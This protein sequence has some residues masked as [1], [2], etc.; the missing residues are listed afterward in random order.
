MNHRIKIEQRGRFTLASVNDGYNSSGSLEKQSTS[1]NNTPIRPQQMPK[2]NDICARELS[3][4]LTEWQQRLDKKNN[5]HI[6]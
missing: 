3:G 2:K 6:R 4:K 1:R 5:G